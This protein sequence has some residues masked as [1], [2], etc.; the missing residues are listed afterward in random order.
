MEG[1][2]CGLMKALTLNLL[3]WTEKNHE[4]RTQ[5]F[6]QRFNLGTFQIKVT[7]VTAT[8]NYYFS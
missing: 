4:H 1:N 3:G 6:W 7:H 8:P 2:S 5:V